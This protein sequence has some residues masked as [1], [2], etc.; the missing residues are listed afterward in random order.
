[1]GVSGYLHA[2]VTL[3]PGKKAGTHRIG[4]WGVPEPTYTF[5]KGEKCFVPTGI[6]TL[7]RQDHSIAIKNTFVNEVTKNL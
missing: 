6:R 7:D 1:M 2:P 5:L 3:S 4:V